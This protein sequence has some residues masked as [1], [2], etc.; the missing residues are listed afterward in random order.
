MTLERVLLQPR[1][2][3][4][5]LCSARHSCGE[6]RTYLARSERRSDRFRARTGHR[7]EQRPESDTT[8]SLARAPVACAT[9]A[10]LRPPW[11]CD[12]AWSYSSWCRWSCVVAVFAYV[13]VR[14]QR[15]QRR[16]GVRP[17]RERHE[18]GDP[19]RRGERASERDA[20]PTSSSLA[21]DLVVKQTE[22]VRIRLLDR[23]LAPR[24][25][26]N[27]LT[28]DPGVSLDRL[29]QVRDTGQPAV[30]EHQGGRDS[31]ST[32]CCCPVRSS[33][34]RRGV[35]EVTF[36]AGRLEA[37]LLG[38]NYKIALRGGRAGAPAGPRR[39]G[40]A[41]APRVPS[42]RRPDAGDR[43]RRGRRGAARRSRC[44]AATSWVRWRRRST[45]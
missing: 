11:D 12:F 39:V 32:P 37:D 8:L 36:V 14:E 9:R 38:E 29:R 34:A 19:A 1:P 10:R 5:Q 17:A 30:V 43:A 20:R 44:G 45:G 35:L 21:H 31:G 24:V 4:S 23:G 6:Q 22:I 25:D 18:R 7:S 15:A 3:S 33:G 13:L 27:L 40:R 42:G 16:S 2:R 41:P 26:A 28:G